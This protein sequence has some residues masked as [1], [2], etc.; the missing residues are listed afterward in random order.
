MKPIPPIMDQVD[1]GACQ[2]Y[3]ICQ[4]LKT[5]YKIELDPI[6]LYEHEKK[7]RGNR[8]PSVEDILNHLKENNYI[9]G[10]DHQY[11]GKNNVWRFFGDYLRQFVPT[12]RSIIICKNICRF[13]GGGIMSLGVPV[14][15]DVAKDGIL[16]KKQLIDNY[17][18]RSHAVFLYDYNDEKG[19]FVLVN[20]W[21]TKVG[22]NT[23]CL[24]LPYEL[25]N[26]TKDLI[27][28]NIKK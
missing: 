6:S 17:R 12:K 15:N 11:V 21:G 4:Y 3:A 7:Q 24:Y 22:D 2:T 13:S 8:D 16:T 1:R 5:I 9:H 23:G 14:G 28:V 18:E 19:V 26:F 10:Y 27:T 25:V 20:S